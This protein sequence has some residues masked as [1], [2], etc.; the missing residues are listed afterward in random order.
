MLTKINQLYEDVKY[1]NLQNYL[2]N[3][4]NICNDLPLKSLKINATLDIVRY[5]Y[6]MKLP[7]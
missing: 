2:S 4:L 1:N 3:V 7:L 5:C 6:F